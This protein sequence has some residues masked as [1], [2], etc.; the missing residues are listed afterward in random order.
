MRPRTRTQKPGTP[1]HVFYFQPPFRPYSGSCAVVNHYL[2]Q[3]LEE[4]G[5]EVRGV[6]GDG[7][8]NPGPA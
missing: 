2:N 1:A 6:Y 5:F 8:R 3:T 4:L 7:Q